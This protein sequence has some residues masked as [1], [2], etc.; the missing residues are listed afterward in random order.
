[1]STNPFYCS[2]GWASRCYR[3][4]SLHLSH[5]PLQNV[6]IEYTYISIL[7]VNALDFHGNYVNSNPR[8]GDT[9]LLKHRF[10]S[11]NFTALQ[12]LLFGLPF[13]IA[14]PCYLPLPSPTIISRLL[15]KLLIVVHSM[16]HA[17]VQH[18]SGLSRSPPL[19]SDLGINT[20]GRI[21]RKCRILQV[22]NWMS[23]G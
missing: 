2:T 20:N 17:L 3:R 4:C 19:T 18:R 10:I 12:L 21:I 6:C 14:N 9:K 22:T 5:S 8:P 11:F 23:R 13:H 7:L 15:F 16:R 1:M